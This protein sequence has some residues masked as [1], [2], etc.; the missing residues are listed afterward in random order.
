MLLAPRIFVS[1]LR[2]H[3]IDIARR[4]AADALSRDADATLPP[5]CR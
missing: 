1:P 5:L 4:Y 2:R 3:A